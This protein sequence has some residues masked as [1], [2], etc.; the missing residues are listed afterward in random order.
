M[1]RSGV[2]PR[3]APRALS[4]LVLGALFALLAAA[5]AAAAPGL[6]SSGPLAPRG[7]GSG[8]GTVDR[9]TPRIVGGSATASSEFPWQV[10][11][12]ISSGGEA[13]SCGGT[14]IHP[15]VVL[16]AAHCLTGEEG[17]FLPGIE[18]TAWLGR[19]LLDSGGTADAASEVRIPKLYE[20][21]RGE[22]DI[23]FVTLSEGSSLARLQLAGPT[24]R[25]LWT[26]GRIETVTGWGE[27]SEEG[28]V[29]PVLQQAQV[30]IV[31][32]AT[33]A[34]P[35]V[36]GLYG[37]T[38]TTMVCAGP[39][40]GGVDS[41]YGDSGG[42]LQAPIDGGGYRLVGVTNWGVGCAR[43]NKPGV[44]ARVAADPLET[45]IAEVVSLIETE[46]ELP[47]TGVDV[48]GSGARPPGCSLAEQQLGEA[49][50]AAAGASGA[51]QAWRA[52]LRKGKRS[53]LAASASLRSALRA[54]RHRL[55]GSGPRL[56]RAR[57]RLKVAVRRV[58]VRHHRLEAARRASIAASRALA[59]AEANRTTVCG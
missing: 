52:R 44:Y 27:T 59:A 58:K 1:G 30:P 7:I 47:V 39:L 20:P 41:C 4:A 33:C 23:G 13:F 21:A 43:P 55:A 49:S 46:D 9:P 17:E 11:L 48:I 14:L 34:Q 45:F 32:D 24:E 10:Q 5:P 37:F 36:N 26:A 12:E 8:G 28:S 29:S 38:A 19:T 35:E 42:P 25:A 31:D 15:Y 18:V 53:R 56:R 40:A 2:V 3:F 16:T 51:A 57:K 6:I 54:R 22:W 50:S